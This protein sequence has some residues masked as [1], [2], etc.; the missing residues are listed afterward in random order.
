MGRSDSR[1]EVDGLGK[2]LTIK[3]MAR[4]LAISP[5]DANSKQTLEMSTRSYIWHTVERS[6]SLSC[7]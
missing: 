3:D 2:T 4:I 7:S 1:G 6:R 5:A